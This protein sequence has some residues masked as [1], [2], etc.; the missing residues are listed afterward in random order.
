ISPYLPTSR[1]TPAAMA[2]IPIARLGIPNRVKDDSPV[3]IS[4]M[5]NR[6]IPIDPIPIVIQLLYLESPATTLA[7]QRDTQLTS[8]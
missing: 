6:S 3:R 8:T 2:R 5:A 1:R 4:Q 7:G